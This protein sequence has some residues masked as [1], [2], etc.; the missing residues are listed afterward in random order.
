MAC[1]GNESADQLKKQVDSLLSVNARYQGDLTNM[2]EYVDILAEGSTPLP[3]RKVHSSILI[4]VKK[5]RW[6]IRPS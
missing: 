1:S 5:A 6:S 4:K 2:N 3:S